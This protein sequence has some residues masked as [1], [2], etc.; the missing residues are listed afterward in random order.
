[1]DHYSAINGMKYLLIHA[2]TWMNLKA[3][4]LREK[5]INKDYILYDSIQV[6]C[7]KLGNLQRQKVDLL[8]PRYGQVGFKRAS[9][10]G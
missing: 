2:T 8:L 3:L 9:G 6:K 1:M 7:S 10:Y 5:S 4:L